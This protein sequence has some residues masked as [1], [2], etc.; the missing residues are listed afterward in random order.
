MKSRRI[1]ITGLSSY[2]GGRLAQ[3]LE[4]EPTVETLIGVDV[5]DPRHELQRTEF[6][7]VDVEHALLSRI[8]RAAAIDTVV[9]TRLIADPMLAPLGRAHAVNVTGTANVLGA[10]ADAHETLRKFVFKS[11]AHYYGHGPDMPAFITENLERRGRPRTE[12]ERDVVQAERAVAQLAARRS[13]LTVTALRLADEIGTEQ[14]SSHLAL[15]GLP[16]VPSILGFDPRFQFIHEDDVVGALAHATRHDLPGA[17][18]AAG[19]GVLVLSEVASLLGKATLPVLPPWGATFA[20]TQLRR[21]GLR[22]PLEMIR[23]LRHG[24]G[25]DN[26]RLK[27]AGF[28]YRYTSREA[29]LQLRAQQRLRPLLRSGEEDYR[30]QPEVEEFLRWSPSVQSAATRRPPEPRGDGVGTA[31]Y[32]ELSTTE[33]LEIISSLEPDALEALRSYERTHQARRPV[34]DA[35]DRALER[36]RS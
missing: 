14:R 23:Q 36:P 19:D 34:L 2:V 25:L 4:R 17:Y 3:A 1:L 18:N 24:R 11:S 22:I 35:L 5:E 6:V 10:C 12:I 7:R 15:L 8:L 16:L 13:H 30:Y 29:V 33:L 27:A 32:D 9:D 28:A 31:A 21:L 20:A 26:R